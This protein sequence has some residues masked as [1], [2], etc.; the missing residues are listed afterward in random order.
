LE[1]DLDRLARERVGSVL[2]EKWTVETLLGVGGMAA[3]Y[4]AR[5]RNGARAAIKVLHP[6][7]ARNKE[8]RERFRREG[9]A[10]NLVEHPGVVKVL[11]DDVVSTGPYAGTVYLVMELLVGELLQDRLERGPAMG[12]IEFLEIA[13]SILEVLDAAHAR[14]VIHRDLKPE[15]IFLSRDESGDVPK[16]RVKVLD[17]GLAR[18]QE[19]ASITAYGL[20]LGTPSFMSPEQAGGRTDEIDG[21]TDLFALAAT[22]FRIRT[23]RR[24]HEAENAVDLVT[25]MAKLPAPPIRSVCP[26]VS[27]PFERVIDKGLQFRREDRFVSAAQMSGDVRRALAELEAAKTQK[28]PRSPSA[29]QAEGAASGAAIELSDADIVR[30]QYGLDESIR[31]PKRRSIVP[32]ILLVAVAGA[33]TKV[34]L[35]RRASFFAPAPPVASEAASIPSAPIPIEAGPAPAASASSDV[36]PRGAG[37]AVSGSSDAGTLRSPDAASTPTPAASHHATPKRSIPVHK[38]PAPHPAAGHPLPVHS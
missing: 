11:D 25:K 15:N 27:A 31:I 17:F 21:R 23:G 7:L 8:V 33:G 24:I 9:Y 22:G 13:A 32:W 38:A 5:H 20:A 10:A 37:V 36:R 29:V 34:W 30:S 12:E 1:D 16:V 3:V 35:D 6:E 28:A 19:G 18:I 26:D 14:G 4:G 2:G